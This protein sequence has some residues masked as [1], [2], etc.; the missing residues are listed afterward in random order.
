MTSDEIEFL[1]EIGQRRFGVDSRNDSP[2]PE[3]LCRAAPKCVVICV[4]AE[5]FVAKQAAEV[6]K[7]TGATAQ[8]ENLKWRRAIEPQ[9]LNVLDVNADPIRG[10][11][12]GVDSLRVGAVRI[13]FAQPF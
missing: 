6:K 11:F 1:P 7:V 4:Q 10:V 5:S 13:M 12:V 8:V 9:I 2:N 3:E